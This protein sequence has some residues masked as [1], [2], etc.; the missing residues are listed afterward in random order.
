ML[1]SFMASLVEFVEAL[2]IVLAVGVTQG[3]RSALLGT[4]AGVVVLLTL[5]VA[6]GRSL[7]AMPLPLV[8]FVVASCC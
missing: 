6:L 2:A 4:A 5:V 1:A 7:S 8:Q 3:W